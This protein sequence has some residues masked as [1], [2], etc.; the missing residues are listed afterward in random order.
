MWIF[1]NFQCLIIYFLRFNDMR[2]VNFKSRPWINSFI[3]LSLNKNPTNSGYVTMKHVNSR[4]ICQLSYFSPLQFLL[5]WFTCI[6]KIIIL[7]AFQLHMLDIFFYS[8][9]WNLCCLKGEKCVWD[10]ISVSY[11]YTFKTCRTKVNG[12]NKEVKKKQVLIAIGNPSA[13]SHR[14]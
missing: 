11:V 7:F 6:F 2:Q 10:A 4:Y 13:I 8:E 9:I 3:P 14:N 12:W 1:C 5:F